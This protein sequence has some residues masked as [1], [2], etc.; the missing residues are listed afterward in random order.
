M[1]V[2]VV[3]TR[4]SALS[5]E[6]SSCPRTRPQTGRERYFR[7][8]K[9]Q[10]LLHTE[11]PQD[12]EAITDESRAGLPRLQ[13]PERSSDPPSPR[14]PS[15]FPFPRVRGIVARA[16]GARSSGNFMLL[17]SDLTT[18]RPTAYRGAQEDPLRTGLRGR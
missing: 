14:A 9:P 2:P 17:F 12:I 11:S 3:S 15:L 10:T 4:Q 8:V 6:A 13:I 5:Q 1:G 7:A 18:S 16:L